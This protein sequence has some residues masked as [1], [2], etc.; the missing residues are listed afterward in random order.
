MIFYGIIL[1]RLKKELKKGL[2]NLLND[3]TSSI[4][5][6]SDIEGRVD[7]SF[8]ENIEDGIQYKEYTRIKEGIISHDEVLELANYMFKHHKLL[9]NILKDKFKF[10]F[11][12]EYQDTNPLVIEIF[13]VHLKQSQKNN[14]IG[15]FGDAMQSI[16][17]DGIGDLKPYIDSKDIEEVLKTQNRRNPQ[18]VINLANKLRTDRLEQEPSTDESA[19][20]MINGVVKN[21]NIK[22]LYSSGKDLDTIKQSV[23][24]TGWDFRN[25]KLT[26]ELNLTHNLI[27]PKAGFPELMEIYD[28]DPIIKLKNDIVEQIKKKREEGVVIEIADDVTF[29]EVVNQFQL[30]KGRGKEK[31]FRKELLLE[32]PIT[33]PLYEQLSGL[34]FSVVRKIYLNKDALIDD[35]KQD[36]DDEN[37]KGSK[38]DRLVKHLFKIQ[39]NIHLYKEK[40][41]NEFLRKTEFK[42]NSIA[43]KQEIKD[44]ISDISEM[45]DY[46]IE[47]VINIAD[48]KGICKKDDSFNQFILSNTYLF[49]RVKSVKYQEFIH[50]YNYLEGF[51]PFSTQ[52]KTKGTEFDN[53][54]VILDNGGWNS[55]YNFK[56]L[57]G[58]GNINQNVLK[59][60]QKIF[61]VCCTRAKENLT[62]FFDSPDDIIIAK[63]KDWFGEEN[64]HPID[65]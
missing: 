49:N 26:K 53:V 27:A 7:I 17:D 8:F 30:T 56:Y 57:F 12:D 5:K 21:G 2:V 14:I 24:F 38:R 44:I 55:N 16:Y 1:K 25:A 28:K 50:L 47:E 54:L 13:L 65:N 6:P 52:H 58:S 60:T 11:I 35:K 61:Y 9:C 39:T 51:T 31:R 43:D 20:N 33:M 36:E 46:T 15:F 19:P 48:E 34:P 22:F 3:D 40:R 10:I 29:D 42:V 62:V 64:V 63:A 32:D 18:S 41:Y 4:K 45:S 59:K 23:H 37:K